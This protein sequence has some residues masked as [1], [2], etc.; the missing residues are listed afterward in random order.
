MTVLGLCS[1]TGS[2]VAVALGPGPA[3][4]GRWALDLRAEGVPAQAYHAAAGLPPPEAEALVRTAVDAAAE[5]A[6]RWLTVLRGELDGEL[7]AV[8]VIVGDYPVPDSVRAILAAHTLMHAAEG[9][10]YREALLDAA[11]D[12]GLHTT[13]VSAKIAAARLAGD[14]AAPIAALGAVA[15]RP[16][17]KEHKLATVAALEVLES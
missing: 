8:A 6:A 11:A 3:L 14:L 17:R 1:R 12:A 4:L 2:A 7:R 16:W 10:L 15:G 9:Q 5:A 13:G